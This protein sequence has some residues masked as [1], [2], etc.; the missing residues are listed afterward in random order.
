[1]PVTPDLM[2][3]SAF[4]LQAYKGITER[5]ISLFIIIL[6]LVASLHTPFLIAKYTR[7]TGPLFFLGFLKTGTFLYRLLLT[8]FIQLALKG[9]IVKGYSLF[10]HCL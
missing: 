7:E 4:D 10:Q 5:R 9:L 1:M 8:L 3:N 2:S 6:S